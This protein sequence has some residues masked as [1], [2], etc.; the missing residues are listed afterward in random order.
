MKAVQLVSILLSLVL[1][2]HVEA[3]SDKDRYFN[4][5]MRQ[6]EKD[7]V[8][9]MNMTPPKFNKSGKAVKEKKKVTLGLRWKMRKH[10]HPLIMSPFSDIPASNRV[11]RFFPSNF[12]YKS[13]I[14]DIVNLPFEFQVPHQPWSGDYWPTYKGGI[15]AR[16][17]DEKYPNSYDFK[18][19]YAAYRN[20]LP[21]K[22]DNN[23]IIDKLSPAEKYDILVGDE[24][25]S[26]T[27]WSFE[28]AQQTYKANN[29]TIETWFGICHGWSPA[30]FMLNRPEKSF[31][32]KVK[33]FQG[34]SMILRFYPDDVKALASTLWANSQTNSY[35]IGGRCNNPSPA[36]D[37][38][39]RILDEECNDLNP[40]AWHIALTNQLNLNQQT[41]VMDASFD[42][43][44]WNQP[45]LS[46]EY[47]FFNPLTKER[48][49]DFQQAMI[50][51]ENYTTD[52]FKK[53]RSSEAKYILGVQMSLVYTSE[54][55][56][57]PQDID[58]AE[59]DNTRTVTYI[60]DLEINAQGQIIGGEWYQNAHPDF[61][62]TPTKT[63]RAQSI[64]DKN[65]TG[66][67][68][69]NAEVPDFWK[70]QAK[71]ASLYGQPIA[72]VVEGLILRAKR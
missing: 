62:W 30:S 72:K 22:I 16:Y 10:I 71:N 28:T 55:T 43:Q 52:N 41:F 51:A 24:S 13:K 19:Y 17:A 50:P 35:F 56:A 36:Q 70:S 31:D 39:G 37:E 2:I 15:G 40:G 29:N 9:A 6:F 65:L 57:E 3:R 38:N 46:Y 34:K 45:V 68:I 18:D 67:W 20:F 7:P 23:Q 61:I 60:Y 21:L 5:F 44:V 25:F 27:K 66:E 4:K 42:N 47:S 63:A 33:N 1:T 58:S 14:T 49:K 48:T 69:G 54:R 8:S 11:S 64:A 32:V 53:Y 26:L 59:A 12:S